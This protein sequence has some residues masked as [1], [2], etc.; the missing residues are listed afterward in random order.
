TTRTRS[1]WTARRS[2]PPRKRRISDRRMWS[3]ATLDLV[4]A[5]AHHLLIFLLAALLAFEIAVVRDVVTR[6]S[7]L[8]L[9]RVDVLYGIVA[10]LILVVGF[11]RAIFAAK[12]WVYYSHNLLFWAKV[13]TFAIVA[14][15]SV[16][17]TVRIIRLRWGFTE[18]SA[19]AAN[20]GDLN[21]VR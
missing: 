6:E 5:I 13:T 4:L 16:A 20:F 12:G 14:L 11:S 8:R 3:Y 21:T 19:F 2:C 18:N 9:S 7:A 15:L 17:P 1:P 10:V